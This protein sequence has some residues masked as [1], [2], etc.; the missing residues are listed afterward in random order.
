MA[1]GPEPSP[2]GAQSPWTDIV[3]A[4]RGSRSV[5]LVLHVRPDGDSVGCSMAMARCL[6]A[7]GKRTRIVAPDPLPQALAF[8]DPGGDCLRPERVTGP[9]DL[10]LFLD[11]AD[12]ERLG[13]AR[14]LL[15]QVPLVVNIDHHGSN[16]RYGQLNYIDASAGAC[17]EIVARLIADLGWTMDPPAATALFTALTTDT[18]SFRYENTSAATLALASRLVQAG[19]DVPT[20]SREVWDSRSLG[21]VRLLSLALSTL[22]LDADGLL[23]TIAVTREMLE[24]SG[25][26]PGDHEGLVDYPRTLRGVEVAALLTADEPGLVRVSLRSNRW[27]D[28]STLAARFGGGGHARAAGCTITGELDAARQTVVASA[29]AALEGGPGTT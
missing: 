13:S 5:L 9:F 22:R 10:G 20:I 1:G 28:V 11:C 17:G 3:A 27:V 15:P 4:V 29:L 23:A 16:R 2:G 6:R 26:A 7:L 12:M 25:T 8:L 21:S 24:E 19:A 18:G 14:E